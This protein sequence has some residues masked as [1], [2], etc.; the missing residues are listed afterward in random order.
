[1]HGNQISPVFQVSNVTGDGLPQ[2][3]RFISLIK[4][5]DMLNK[6]YGKSTDPLEYDINENFMIPGIGLVV[7]GLVKSGVAKLNSVVLLGPTP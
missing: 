2:L 6:G 5:R 1:M 4:N 3:T 7:S